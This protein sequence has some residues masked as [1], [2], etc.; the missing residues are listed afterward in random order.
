LIEASG[1]KSDGQSRK[2]SNKQCHGA[3]KRGNGK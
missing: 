1:G 2:A 3:D